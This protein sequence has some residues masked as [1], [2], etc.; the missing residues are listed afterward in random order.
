MTHSPQPSHFDSSMMIDEPFMDGN[1]A[2]QL[3][4]GAYGGA[5]ATDIKLKIEGIQTPITCR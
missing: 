5:P 3:K 1:M 2:S 4:K